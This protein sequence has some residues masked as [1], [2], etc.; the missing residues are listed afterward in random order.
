MIKK[1]NMP[2]LLFILAGYNLDDGSFAFMQALPMR[3]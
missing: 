3:N 2:L 1:Q